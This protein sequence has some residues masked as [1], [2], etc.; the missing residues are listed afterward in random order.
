MIDYNRRGGHDGRSHVWH[1]FAFAVKDKTDRG[2]VMS[3]HRFAGPLRFGSAGDAVK[4]L[5][6]QLNMFSGPALEVDGEFG[7]DTRRR[8]RWFQGHRG[9]GAD[10]VVDAVTWAFIFGQPAPETRLAKRRRLRH[11]RAERRLQVMTATGRRLADLTRR[12]RRLET[13]LDELAKPETR[14]QKIS[15]LR[16]ETE[17]ARGVRARAVRAALHRLTVLP[18]RERAWGVAGTCVGIREVGQ[19]RG[20]R[21]DEIIDYAGG[22]RGEP[23]CVDGLIWCFGRSGSDAV[24]PGYPRAVRLML[25][26]GVV[27]TTEPQT[28]ELVRYS[29]DHT[30]LFGYWARLVAGSY[31]KCPRALATHI[32]TREFNTSA[33]GALSSDAN[34][35]RDGVYVKVRHRSLITDFLRVTR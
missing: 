26:D 1:A 5:Q 32:V 23:Y 16:A 10:G 20:R 18:L 14:E 25:T 15:R 4:A 7:E 22:R 35:G 8:V 6:R 27:R 19:N 31:M 3:G 30:G 28:G 33:T 13:A 2:I 17:T 34:E 29:F 24:R 9:L 11:E 21:V 12:L